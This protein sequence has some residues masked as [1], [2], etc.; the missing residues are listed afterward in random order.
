M[1]AVTINHYDV[2]RMRHC[3]NR[4]CK[5]MRRLIC[6]RSSLICVMIEVHHLAFTAHRS[7]WRLIWLIVFSS[8]RC[9]VAIL[10]CRDAGRIWF[11]TFKIHPHEHQTGVKGREM[12]SMFG[13]PAAAF[14]F[15]Y[16]LSIYVRKHVIQLLD[17]KQVQ[18]AFF[19]V[20]DHF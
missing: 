19:L 1:P 8:L 10:Y 15:S 14:V 5:E 16:F 20:L 6:K 12:T 9:T 11:H 13:F 3:I 7:L 2:E 4:L 18:N 17:G